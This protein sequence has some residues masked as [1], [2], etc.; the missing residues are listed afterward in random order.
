[1]HIEH[2]GKSTV[3]E[4]AQA[5]VISSSAATQLVDGLVKSG[6]LLRE[7]PPHDRRTTVLT[8]SKKTKAQVDRMKQ[9]TIQTFLA[10]F[11]ALSDQ[12]FEQFCQLHQK[13]ARHIGGPKFK[14][15]IIPHH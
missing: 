2:Q 6:Y 5:L 3:K 13:I 4:V 11:K 10:A 9:Q 7:T 1:M 15:K 8:L 14:K 12:E